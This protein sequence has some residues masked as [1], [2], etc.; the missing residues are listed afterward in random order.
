MLKVTNYLTANIGENDIVQYL[1]Y[2]IIFW[3]N[4]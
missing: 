3:V 1:W 4:Y 2:T